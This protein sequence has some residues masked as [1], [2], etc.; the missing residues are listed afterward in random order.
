MDELVGKGTL[1]GALDSGL[2][3]DQGVNEYFKDSVNEVCYGSVR[4]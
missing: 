1:G 3:I 4:L 2:N